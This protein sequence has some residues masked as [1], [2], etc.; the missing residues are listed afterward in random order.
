MNLIYLSKM[1]IYNQLNILYLNI[2]KLLNYCKKEFLNYDLENI[3][4]NV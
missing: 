1:L 2:K 3:L 4:N